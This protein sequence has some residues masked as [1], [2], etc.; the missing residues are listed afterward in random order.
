MT[1]ERLEEIGRLL[2]AGV[3]QIAEG[4]EEVEL[5]SHLYQAMF[6]VA[7]AIRNGE[8]EVGGVVFYLVSLYNQRVKVRNRAE[9]AG[10]EISR[11]VLVCLPPKDRASDA[12]RELQIRCHGWVG[13]DGELQSFAIEK[14]EELDYSAADRRLLVGGRIVRR[15]LSDFTP[16][17]L[18][19]ISGD[20]EAKAR[21]EILR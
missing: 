18:A 11:Y 20:A 5:D 10:S 16:E 14:I 6:D 1:E 2:A 3:R 8:L 17:E 12:E 19:K 4:D 15:R 21:E 7:K 13:E 9:S